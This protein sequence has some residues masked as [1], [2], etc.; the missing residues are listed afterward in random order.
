MG[1]FFVYGGAD[2]DLYLTGTL[3]NLDG[4]TARF[5]SFSALCADFGD[6]VVCYLTSLQK[7]PHRPTSGETT[8]WDAENSSFYTLEKVCFPR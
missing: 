8:I 3:L 6:W 4:K 5:Q 7:S 2:L 1:L